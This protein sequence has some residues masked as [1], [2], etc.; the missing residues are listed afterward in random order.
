MAQMTLQDLYQ[1]VGR[2]MFREDWT[3]EEFRQA[4]APSIE[5]VR[6]RLN[7]LAALR[8]EILRW[9]PKKDPDACVKELITTDSETGF[10]QEYMLDE[11]TSQKADL[12]RSVICL[13]TIICWLKD[14][15]NAR[16]ETGVKFGFAARLRHEAH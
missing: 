1:E 11:P 9:Y 4:G 10:L 3:G 12:Y 5:E 15:P 14:Y 2:S 13:H 16:D 8:K 7:E 6:A